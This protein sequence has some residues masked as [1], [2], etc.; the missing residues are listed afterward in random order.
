[1]KPLDYQPKYF[2]ELIQAN[3]IPSSFVQEPLCI[4]IGQIES[5]I[6]NL[7]KSLITA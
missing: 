2:K 7:I 1:M 5:V 3:E 4:Q 6:I